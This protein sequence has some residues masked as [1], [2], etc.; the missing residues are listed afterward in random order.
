MFHLCSPVAVAA[1]LVVVAVVVIIGKRL[2]WFSLCG[3]F[4]EP[5]SRLCNSACSSHGRKS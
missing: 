3:Q 4:K 1:A 5:T 2:S